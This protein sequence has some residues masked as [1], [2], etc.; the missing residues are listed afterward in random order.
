MQFLEQIYLPQTEVH[1]VSGLFST[2]ASTR[3]IKLK[4][5]LLLSPGSLFSNRLIQSQGITLQNYKQELDQFD[6]SRL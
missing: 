3:G 2:R 5:L 4:T 6:L 1:P